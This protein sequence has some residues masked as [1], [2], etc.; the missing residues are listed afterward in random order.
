MCVNTY[1]YACVLYICVY[2]YV[3]M[4]VFECVVYMWRAHRCVCAC[5]LHMYM[6]H[7]VLEARGQPCMWF[8]A[9]HHFV[10]LGNGPELTK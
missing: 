2:V 5:V 9:S 1:M 10:L 3:D 8:L 6:F 4:Y 7:P